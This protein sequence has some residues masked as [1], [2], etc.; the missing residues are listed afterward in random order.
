MYIMSL[1]LLAQYSS[2]SDHESDVEHETQYSNPPAPTPEVA[3]EEGKSFF[4]DAFE[5]TESS[6]S[7]ESC[8]ENDICYK[9]SPVE[10]DE[11]QLPLPELGNIH[12][13]KSEVL[14]GSV[15]SNPFKEAEDAKL[16]VLQK[17]VN[18]A[19]SEE[20]L[21]PKNKRTKFAHANA[22][23]NPQVV[24][25]QWDKHDS[26]FKGEIRKHKKSGM[27]GGLV[28]PK[29]YMRLHQELQAKERP[30]TLK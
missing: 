11:T 28:P 26:S 19:P 15:F 18:L 20:K 7:D 1:G 10:H 13:G 12:A 5:S 6:T 17:H 27:S 21:Q 4:E 24:S 8:E 9:T 22:R 14:P 2:E 25:D 3:I 29:K 23:R 30:W 16:S